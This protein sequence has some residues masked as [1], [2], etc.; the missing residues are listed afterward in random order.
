LAGGDDEVRTLRTEIARLETRQR[1][2]QK[3]IVVKDAY[4]AAL[5]AELFAK[6]AEN[7]VLRESMA[8]LHA[9][10]AHTLSQPR[11]RAADAVNRALRRFKFL[12]ALLKR[13][14][15]GRNRSVSSPTGAASGAS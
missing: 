9:S 1:H 3:D 15:P 5:R 10:I 13:A 4:L 11:Y 7:A 8:R 14:F 12:H 6:E 2:L